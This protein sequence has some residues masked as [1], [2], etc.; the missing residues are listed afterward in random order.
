MAPTVRVVL[1][2][3]NQVFRET[4]ELLLGLRGDMEVVAS[5]QGGAEAIETCGRLRPD[6][7]LVDYR[8]PGLNGAQTT[9]GVLAAS[10]ATRVVCLTASVAEEETAELEAAGAVACV[11]KDEDLDR[12]VAAIHRAVEGAGGP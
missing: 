9:A 4:L 12:I 10:P 1:V 2:E 5:V 8:M 6:V 7:V 11:R 3:D